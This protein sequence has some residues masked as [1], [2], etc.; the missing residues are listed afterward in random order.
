SPEVQSRIHKVV[1][2]ANDAFGA[3]GGLKILKDSFNLIPDAISGVC[4]RS[5]LHIRELS[6]FT[7]IPVFNSTDQNL[8]YLYRLLSS[9]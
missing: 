5:P 3:I 1:F 6:I 9:T 2:C 8:N 7:E 4:S